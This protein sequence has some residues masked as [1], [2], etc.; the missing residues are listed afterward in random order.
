MNN[1]NLSSPKNFR[2]SK[3]IKLENTHMPN[4]NESFSSCA[5]ISLNNVYANGDYFITHSKDIDV[6]NLNING[7]YCFDTCKNITVK[8]SKIISKDAFW[9]CENVEV[10]DSFIIGEY[11]AWNSKNISFINCKIQS[12]QAL[13]YIQ[14]LR[15]V[16]CELLD[17][18]LAFEYSTVD[19][20]VSSKIQSIFNPKSGIIKAKS[21][22]EILIDEANSKDVQI[23]T[24]D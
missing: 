23:I 20:D 16:N 11:L 22:D 19:V 15:L 21:I 17:T 1:S 9:N 14:N 18:T 24:K 2:H 4:A 3:N 7:N 6:N 12:L 8:N 10:Y 13:C 5:N